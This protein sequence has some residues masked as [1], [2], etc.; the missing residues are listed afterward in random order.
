MNLNRLKTAR[1]V[2]LTLIGFAL[3]VAG[4]W[5]VMADLFGPIIGSGTGLALSGLALLVIEGLSS[6][7]G[8][9]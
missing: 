2:A 7:P 9:R 3:I 6:G 4:I 8:D 1:T 5:T